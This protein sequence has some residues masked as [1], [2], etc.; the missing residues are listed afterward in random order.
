MKRYEHL[1]EDS[2]FGVN[3]VLEESTDGSVVKVEDLVERLNSA[4]AEGP[5]SCW[6]S[7]SKLVEELGN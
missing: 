2:L 4:L 1:T 3:S 5:E 7:L 6:R